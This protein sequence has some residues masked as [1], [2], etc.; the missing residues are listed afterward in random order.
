MNDRLVFATNNSHKLT[1]ARAILGARLSLMS[2]A[3]IECFDDIPETAATLEGNAMLKAR[4]IADRYGMSVIADDTG[5]EVDALGGAPGVYSARYAGP[6]HDSVA[7]VAKLLENMRGVTDRRARFRTVI[8]M[9]SADGSTVTVDGVVEGT[10]TEEPRGEGG[11][12]YDSVFMP[13]GYDR[14]FAQMSDKE[15]NSLSHR[16][17][18]LEALLKRLG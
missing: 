2:L 12:G 6:Q 1:E 9:I 15:K 5:L 11:F 3:D 7:N 16:S 13:V 4:Y 17:R 18:A 8:A 14:T 10:I